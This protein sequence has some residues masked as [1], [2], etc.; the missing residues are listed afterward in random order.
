MTSRDTQS[1]MSL[2]LRG[3]LYKCVDREGTK[4]L[5]KFISSYSAASG[6]LLLPTRRLS[7]LATLRVETQ[8]VLFT[9]RRSLLA[10]AHFHL[11]CM[12]VFP[13]NSWRLMNF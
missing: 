5:L 7:S 8:G 10:S 13:F 11:Q 3:D 12:F 6:L 1:A 9:L 2:V 4:A